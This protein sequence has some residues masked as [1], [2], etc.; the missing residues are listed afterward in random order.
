[1][2][3]EYKLDIDQGSTF[4]VELTIK[5]SSGSAIDITGRTFTGQIRSIY[6]A[7]TVIATFTCAITDATA[8]K[9][10]F[11]LTAAETAAI[12]V[13][14][15]TGTERTKTRYIYDIE[16]T[17]GSTVTRI[18]QGNVDISPEVTRA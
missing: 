4:S 16:M 9:M 6:S 2:A 17:N 12:T 13:D 7:A 15:A 3:A 14:A 10:T 18:L 8:G 11:S 1:M 5:D